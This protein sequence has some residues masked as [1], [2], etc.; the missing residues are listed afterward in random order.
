MGIAVGEEY[1]IDENENS[2]SDDVYWKLVVDSVRISKVTRA[3]SRRTGTYVDVYTNLPNT[4][5]VYAPDKFS[6]AC[7]PS[8]YSLLEPNTVYRTK[9]R[10]RLLKK[11]SQSN[12]VWQT[13]KD[14]T[15]LAQFTTGGVPEYYYEF[16]EST[17]PKAG[18]KSFRYGGNN[19]GRV[20]VRFSS[21][22]PALSSGQVVG[23]LS[24]HTAGALVPGTWTRPSGDN[25][26]WAFTPTGNALQ[27]NRMYVLRLVDLSVDSTNPARQK[28]SM[29][30]ETGNHA[31]LPAFA[32]V[33]VKSSEKTLY[34]IGSPPVVFPVVRNFVFSLTGPQTVDWENVTSFS[35]QSIAGTF[36]F[37]P[38][39][40]RAMILGGGSKFGGGGGGSFGDWRNA[41]VADAQTT[42]QPLYLPQTVPD[43]I[44]MILNH[45]YE[46]VVTIPFSR[47]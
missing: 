32:A 26:W 42:G 41:V 9:V 27:P 43:P 44:Q 8:G 24:D 22:L 10:A 17:Y 40:R 29:S 6:L 47:P 18:E 37:A 19:S 15:A 45:R 28:Y 30:F 23:Q 14:T 4:T 12:W 11:S 2:T 7:S 20:H 1:F 34:H 38:S 35:L 13:F 25:R 36:E 5:V 39:S 16:V 3:F 21:L 33:A 31:S 46:G